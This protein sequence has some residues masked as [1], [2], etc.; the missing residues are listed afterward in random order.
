[1][2]RMKRMSSLRVLAL[3]LVLSLVVLLNS[4][5]PAFASI[6]GQ[7]VMVTLGDS[8]ACGEGTEPFYDQDS[9]NRYQSDDFLA[10]RSQRAWPSMLTVSGATMQK[11]QNW[12]FEAASGAR[13][14]HVLRDKLTKE[15]N[16][17]GSGSRELR[18]QKEVFSANNLKGLVDYVTVTVGG[19]DI[20][21]ADLVTTAAKDDIPLVT[22]GNFEAQI[23]DSLNTFETTTKGQLLAIYDMVEQEAGSQAT[24]IAVGYPHLF[25][26]N[27]TRVYILGNLSISGIDSSEAAL[28]NQAVDVFDAGIEELV[29]NENRENLVYCEVRPAFD[30]HESEYINPIW[31]YEKD[32]DIKE[33]ASGYSVHPNE[34]GQRAYASA[35]QATID[36]VEEHKQTNPDPVDPDP[37]DDATHMS[38]A[39]VLDVSGSMKR[40]SA[41]S[42]V[43]KLKSATRQCKDFVSTVMASASESDGSS[44]K[45][46]VST[47]SSQANRVCALSSDIAAINKSL[48]SLTAWGLSNL[49]EGLEDGIAQL[50]PEEGTK[51]LI[52]LS[53]GKRNK[54]KEE[55]EIIALAR[56]AASAGIKI[57]AIGFG[58][59][60]DLDVALLQQIAQITGGT[61]AH[62]DASSLSS[63][64]VGLFAQMMRVEL[65]AT[66]EVLLEDTGTVAQDAATEVGSFEVSEPG[67][68][69]AYLYGSDSE[70]DLQLTDPD[71]I[72]VTGGYEGSTVDDAQALTTITVKNA[73]QGT[74]LM[75]VHGREVSFEEEPFYAAA[76]MNENGGLQ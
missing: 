9:P 18:C 23:Q 60:D 61:Y 16:L 20:G 33:G 50:S 54:G 37:G 46:G 58:A 1:M 63:A 59:E 56:K 71:G 31:N 25:G 67:T 57:Y 2:A 68:M 15:W 36:L 55:S 17:N 34:Q 24:T 70:L 73:K 48:D 64:T 65:Q 52:L 30:G 11:D 69:T 26:P 19:N 12:F 35:V 53:D 5:T 22:S 45:V 13:T 3:S 42:G 44:V 38:L 47:F 10:H 75:Q 21:F 40:D 8:Y 39:L 51:M 14:N 74:W 72:V 7:P 27:G 49:Y 76:S 28:F 4:V 6:N 32:Y 66:S 62:E 41:V 29:A 43:T